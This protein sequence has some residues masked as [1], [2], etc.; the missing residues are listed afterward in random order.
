MTTPR[1]DFTSSDGTAS[2]SRQPM[3]GPDDGRITENRLN[4]LDLEARGVSLED[5]QRDRD[6]KGV[7]NGYDDSLATRKGDGEGEDRLGIARGD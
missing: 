4:N 6:S 1:S 7:K 5:H 2:A 3:N